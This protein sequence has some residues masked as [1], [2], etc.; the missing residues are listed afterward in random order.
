MV[1]IRPTMATV[2]ADPAVAIVG[3]QEDGSEPRQMPAD[4]ALAVWATYDRILNLI[5]SPE[6]AARLHII[7]AQPVRVT[8]AILVRQ[9]A[10]EI[11][12]ID[13]NDDSA[14]LII[15]SWITKLIFEIESEIH[16][17]IEERNSKF[18]YRTIIEDPTGAPS[19]DDLA[20]GLGTSSWKANEDFKKM[21]GKTIKIFLFEKKMEWAYR[22]ISQSSMLIKELSE[23]MGYSGT[24]NFSTA[25]SKYFG[26]S[27]RQLRLSANVKKSPM[28]HEGEDFG[29]NDE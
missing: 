3:I 11:T 17:D 10:H 4:C 29:G 8:N 12:K 13:I 19:I 27:P 23:I 5:G 21:Y 1:A 14:K 22:N 26:V 16:L 6:A 28:S 18:I 2:S 20:K 7:L 9:I 15:K 25:F 24:S